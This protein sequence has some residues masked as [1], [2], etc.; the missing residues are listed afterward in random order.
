[1]ATL[2]VL[3]VLCNI[4]LSALFRFITIVQV[5]CTVSQKNVTLF[6]ARQHSLLCRALS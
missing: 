1:M 3:V 6:T 5:T 4:L 2:Y